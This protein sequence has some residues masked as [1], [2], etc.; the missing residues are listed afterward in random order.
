MWK[1]TAEKSEEAQAVLE[2]QKFKQQKRLKTDT[3]P[4]E[5]QQTEQDVSLMTPFEQVATKGRFLLDK[6]SKF[7]L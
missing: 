6:R 7:S 2:F 3:K 5:Y 1:W 4:N